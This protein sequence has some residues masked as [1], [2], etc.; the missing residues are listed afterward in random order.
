MHALNPVV[1]F[2]KNYQNYSKISSI[3]WLQSTNL[4]R[5][6]SHPTGF[7]L[8]TYKLKVGDFGD[9]QVTIRDVDPNDFWS[10]KE[11]TSGWIPPK[12][13]KVRRILQILHVLFYCQCLARMIAL[14]TRRSHWRSK[15]PR[16]MNGINNVHLKFKFH[17]NLLVA[18]NIFCY[19][20]GSFQFQ[21]SSWNLIFIWNSLWEVDP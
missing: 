18:E 5:S 13:G 1:S 7:V 12:E 3:N 15:Q 19:M 14:L 6:F 20:F 8:D 11:A 9:D 16:H 10:G 4:G 21:F 17:T 2:I